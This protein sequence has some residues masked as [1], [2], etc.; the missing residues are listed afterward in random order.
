[1]FVV[2]ADEAISKSSS[3]ELLTIP[4]VSPNPPKGSTKT[5]FLS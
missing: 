5:E 1:L 2:D 4:V 3:I